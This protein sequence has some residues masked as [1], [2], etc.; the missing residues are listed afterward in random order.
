MMLKCKFLSKKRQQQQQTEEREKLTDERFWLPFPLP[1]ASTPGQRYNK[2]I[3]NISVC[4]KPNGI[5]SAFLFS[6]VVDANFF[7]FVSILFRVDH[8]RFDSV[9]YASHHRSER[10]WFLWI[11]S[12]VMHMKWALWSQTRA[13]APFALRSFFI[14]VLSCAFHFIY[15]VFF[16]SCF[17]FCSFF[18]CFFP[19]Q[20]A[21]SNKGLWYRCWTQ[22]TSALWYCWN[23]ATS[24]L[25]Y[26]LNNRCYKD[27][28]VIGSWKDAT[29]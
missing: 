29:L 13:R 7:E 23:D 3:I 16:F 5:Q 24:L 9:D 1:T 28:D 11:L 27:C 12:D 26:W 8:H 14:S 15:R 6:I 19:L 21:I 25:P 20:R 17:F 10:M 18:V 22:F 4:K 2:T